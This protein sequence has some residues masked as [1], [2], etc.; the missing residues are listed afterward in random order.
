MGAANGEAGSSHSLSVFTVYVPVGQPKPAR[1][2]STRQRSRV[3][4]S[5][6]N[7]LKRFPH[8]RF[9]F[10][11]RPPTHPGRGDLQASHRPRRAPRGWVLVAPRCIFSQLADMP[12][13]GQS[14][15]PCLQFLRPVLAGLSL[16]QI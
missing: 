4:H 13:P 15:R 9:P 2:H 3:N 16:L 6:F 8:I 10:R 7:I 1:T 12:Q 5:R 11:Q 14:Y